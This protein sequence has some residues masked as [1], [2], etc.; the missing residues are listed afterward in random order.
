[1]D[2][3]YRIREINKIHKKLKV[4]RAK[5]EKLSAN[6][7]KCLKILNATEGVLAVSFLGLNTVSVVILPTIVAAPTVPAI[8]AVSL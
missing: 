2:N 7:L 8:Q 4:E 3:D 1:M 5:R 6:Y